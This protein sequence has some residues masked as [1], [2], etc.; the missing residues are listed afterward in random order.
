MKYTF[1]SILQALESY[2]AVGYTSVDVD[3]FIDAFCLHHNLQREREERRI[4]GI[5]D[6][7][8]KQKKIER[9]EDKIE[10]WNMVSANLRLVINDKR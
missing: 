7:L 4:Y 6:V 8:E 3:S 10:L 2:Y 9:K 1:R 5:L